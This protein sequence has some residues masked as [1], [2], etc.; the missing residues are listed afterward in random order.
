MRR[1]VR[2]VRDEVSIAFGSRRG[3]V[4]SIRVVGGPDGSSREGIR[5]GS[6]G[7]MDLVIVKEVEK[8]VREGL[9]VMILNSGSC[10]ITV[11]Y[12]R[13]VFSRWGSGR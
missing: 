9:G 1:D 12:I 5:E 10:C 2:R 13:E 7:R 3:T 11:R 6:R 8:I 4:F